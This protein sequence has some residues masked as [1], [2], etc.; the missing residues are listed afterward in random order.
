M[1]IAV[2]V[3]RRACRGLR[4]W[5]FRK[6]R[7][8]RLDRGGER[9]SVRHVARR[10]VVTWRTDTDAAHTTQRDIFRETRQT[11]NR[12]M[13]A[14]KTSIIHREH[15][16]SQSPRMTNETRGARPRKRAEYEIRGARANEARIT[17]AEDRARRE[18][19]RKRERERV[20]S[21]SIRDVRAREKIAVLRTGAAMQKR[22]R[23]RAVRARYA[24]AV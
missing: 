14:N 13:T 23:R 22:Q 6:Y 20:A 3:V 4:Y 18:R 7:T 2:G 11:S 15:L 1:F 19:E 8:G 16:E 12:V 17:R 10:P 9:G 21:R 5:P 24:H